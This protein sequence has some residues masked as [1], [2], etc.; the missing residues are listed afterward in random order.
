MIGHI[1]PVAAAVLV[2]AWLR[3]LVLD[4]LRAVHILQLEEYQTTRYWRWLAENIA[5]SVN[6]WLVGT[7][8]VVTI[9]AIVAPARVGLAM[10]AIA[11][12]VGFWQ[13]LSRTIP[14]AKKPLILTARARRLAAGYLVSSLVVG[15]AVGSRMIIGR[16]DESSLPVATAAAAALLVV[17]L[18]LWP[19]ASLANLLLFPIEA[20]FRS[21]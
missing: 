6:L 15:Y 2:V 3:I 13:S 7:F 20:G 18:G 5:L 17:G 4:G 19:L 21:Y 8:L 10:F 16:G 12:G 14:T 1:D 11:A 9:V